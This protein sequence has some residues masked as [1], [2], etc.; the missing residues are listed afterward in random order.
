MKPITPGYFHVGKSN[1]S[2]A[3]NSAHSSPAF[4][5]NYDKSNYGT[6]RELSQEMLL[7]EVLQ[8]LATHNQTVN[9]L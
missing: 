3:S 1:W 8:V 5:E 9:F 4:E 7:A 2:A 6:Y